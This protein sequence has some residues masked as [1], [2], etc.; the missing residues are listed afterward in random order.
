MSGSQ[1]DITTL[2]AMV[3]MPIGRWNQ[4]LEILGAHPWREVNPVIVD[5]HRQLQDAVAAQTGMGQ[6]MSTPMPM[7][8]SVREPQ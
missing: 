2:P 7:P 3:T 8:A 6:T 1:Q 4:V 5:I